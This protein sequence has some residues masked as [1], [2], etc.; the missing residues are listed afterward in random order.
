M[1]HATDGAA[2]ARSFGFSERVCQLIG[3]HVTAKRYLVR[4]DSRYWQRLSDESKASLVEQGGTLTLNEVKIF[5]A[6]IYFDD[7]IRL[8]LA[9]DMAKDPARITRD[10]E[11]FYSIITKA[12][13]T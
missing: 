4:I 5:E 9:D 3:L 1:K 12:L 13:R 8:R 10:L 2:I 7:S 6:S 11:S